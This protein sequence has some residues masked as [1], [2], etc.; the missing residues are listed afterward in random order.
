MC[1]LRAIAKAEGV[2]RAAEKVSM[3]VKKGGRGR[4]REIAAEGD[5]NTDYGE[6]NEY[7]SDQQYDVYDYEEYYY[8]DDGEEEG[9]T[10]PPQGSAPPTIV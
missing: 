9:N 8:E 1:T 7:D 3:V 2:A 5:E 6:Y 4:I 10:P